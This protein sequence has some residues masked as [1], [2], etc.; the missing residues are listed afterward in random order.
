MKHLLYILCILFALV[1][2][3]HAQGSNSDPDFDEFSSQQEEQWRQFVDQQQ[4]DWDSYKREIENQWNEF[5]ASTPHVFVEYSND[6]HTRSIVDFKDGQLE[7]STLVPLDT[8][9]PEAKAKQQIENV[10]EEVVTKPEADGKPLLE[11]QLKGPD[12]QPITPRTVQK[13][14]REIVRQPKKEIITRKDGSKRIKYT[15]KLDFVS[16]HLKKRIERYLPMVKQTCQRFNIP[17]PLALGI[18][19][20]E[21]SFNYKAYNRKGNAYGLMQIVPRFAGRTMNK[22][23]YN[24]DG[25]PTP[26]QLFD[27]KTNLEM[28]IGYLNFLETQWFEHVKNT[29]NRYYCM[30]CAY[31]GGA[32]NVLKSVTGR[33]KKEARFFDSV[34][35][36]SPDQ[37]YTH[38]RRK[39][40]P[41][42]TR[43]YIK[44]VKKYA[45]QFG[46][47]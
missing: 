30:I 33:M 9:D 3:L 21:S 16:D 38:L 42:E 17:L 25:K 34:N 27:P 8:P 6:N 37:Y 14:V 24:R 15:V 44:N 32:G 28:G 40:P 22:R 11:D 47:F 5:R 13:E 46:G 43:H 18:I 23:L 39:L 19:R 12:N 10:I 7:I 1:V 36:M 29:T 26:E 2:S 31:N 45:D 35:K 41:E 20:A 4:S